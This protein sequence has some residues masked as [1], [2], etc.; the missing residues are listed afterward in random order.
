MCD[1][2][3]KCVASVLRR[4]EQVRTCLGGWRINMVA[5]MVPVMM[6]RIQVLLVLTKI[7]RLTDD[8]RPEPCAKRSIFQLGHVALVTAPYA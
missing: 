3:A 7:C 1:M 8:E 6:E 2:T 5:E 4:P